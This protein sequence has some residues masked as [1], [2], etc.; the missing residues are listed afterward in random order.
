MTNSFCVT[1]ECTNETLM[2]VYDG[3]GV[4]IAIYYLSPINYTLGQKLRHCWHI[5][6]T[7]HPYNDQICLSKRDAKKLAKWLNKAL[8]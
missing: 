7:G 2:A 4:D 5:L 8:N 3:N 1:C 6:R